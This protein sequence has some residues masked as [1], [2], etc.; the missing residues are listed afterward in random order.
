MK[1]K[2]PVV[3][4]LFNNKDELILPSIHTLYG[5]KN[6]K[7]GGNNNSNLTRQK[8][9]IR[10]LILDNSNTKEHKNYSDNCKSTRNN[11]S[12]KKRLLL[13]KNISNNYYNDYSNN[14]NNTQSTVN[15]TP[16]RLKKTKHF[17]TFRTKTKPNINILKQQ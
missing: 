12:S 9:G 6:N 7:G 11:N 10:R 14:N 8:Y 1:K 5:S 17:S 4:T 15:E 2:T 3:S 16:I 13:L